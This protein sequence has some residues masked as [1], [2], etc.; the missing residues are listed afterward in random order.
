VRH[1]G[2]PS[3]GTLTR[4]LEELELSGFIT[5]TPPFLNVKKEKLY[6]LMDE[7]S[8]FYLRFIDGKKTT[9]WS[10][11]SQSQPF[12]LWQGYAFENFCFRHIKAI[13][14]KL[15][16]AAV[17]TQQ[18]SYQIKSNQLNGNHQIDLLID[19]NDQCI[20]LCEIKYHNNPFTI[21]KQYA[22]I[23]RLRMQH[24][25][26]ESGTKKTVFL[27]FI[28]KHGTITQSGVENIVDSEVLLKD[29]Y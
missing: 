13:K 3:G 5:S 20:N 29:F 7:F 12:K 23:L 27:T 17:V 9:D 26:W 16:I 24:F 25:G 14:Q 28:T 22:E 15:G 8:V 4:M 10:L 6:R 21:T 19:R 11:I 2:I 1:S 18:Y